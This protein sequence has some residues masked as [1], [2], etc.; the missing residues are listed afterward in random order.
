M[1][2]WKLAQE[3]ERNWWLNQAEKI[4]LTFYKNFAVEIVDLLK[5][6]IEIK[7]STKILEIG[8]GAAGIITHLQS[9]YRF[10]IDPLEDFYSSITKY[11]NY[12]DKSVLYQ[13]AVGENLPFKSEFFD[14]ILMD[15]VLDHCDNPL[16]VLEEIRRV[17]KKEGVLYFRQN[18]YHLWGRFIR[19]VMEFFLVDKGHPHT[20]SKKEL[21][22]VFSKYEFEILY[23][24]RD[25]YF[26]TW[27]WEI[28]SNRLIDKIKA[29]LL[30]NRDKYTLVLRK[31]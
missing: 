17:L 21:H 15:N 1:S 14:L 3:Y 2:R 28:K 5:P 25:G 12:R 6:F 24:S 11:K 4:D 22:K 29:V 13:T 8:S 9:D 27:L 10:A 18:T 23:K 20:F 19:K 31:L 16:L 7:S 26:S 30:V